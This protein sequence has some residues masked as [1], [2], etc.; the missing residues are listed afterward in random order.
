M[1][2]APLFSPYRQGE[3]RITA[4]LMAVFERIDLS[5]VERLL[6]V[7]SG[8]SALLVPA[9]AFSSL[10]WAL[11]RVSLWRSSTKSTSVMRP[12]SRPL[13]VDP[14]ELNCP[15]VQGLFDRGQR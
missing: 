7:S 10:L 1:P 14:A 12:A 6:A 13:L 5:K 15:L 3:N 4:S 9:H 2:K 11:R 8:E